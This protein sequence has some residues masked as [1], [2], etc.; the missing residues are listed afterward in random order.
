MAVP[1][2]RQVVKSRWDPIAEAQH[3]SVV[4]A[5]GDRFYRAT[6]KAVILAGQAHTAHRLVEHLID[7]VTL[8]AWS[9]FTLVPVVMANV[10]LRRA[11]PLV[12]L[13]LG[14]NNYWWG[15]QYWVDFVIA[16][17]VTSQRHDPNRSTVLTLYGA[18]VLPPEDMPHERVQLLRTPFAAYEQSLREDLQR[19]LAGAGSILIAM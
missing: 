1:P 11:A 2:G 10:T 6:A 4:Y 15:S 13:G 14:F 17:W 16:D 19:I 5:F 9:T 7:D 12:D 3:A 18:N 8:K